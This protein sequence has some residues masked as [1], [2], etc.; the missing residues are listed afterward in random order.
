[1]SDTLD[2]QPAEQGAGEG[3]RLDGDGSFT[4][5]PMPT[6]DLLLEPEAVQDLGLA[7]L[8]P[9]QSIGLVF[10]TP[11]DGRSFSLA[12]RLRNAG[13]DGRL[14]ALG[15]LMPDQAR[16][17]MQSG[18]DGLWLEQD[19]VERHNEAAWRAALDVV[20]ARL[21]SQQRLPASLAG[22]LAGPDIWQQRSQG[23]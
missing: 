11:H 16:H 4:A 17:A 23:Q 2:L 3:W 22:R 9:L 1:M 7:N 8:L 12:R 14:V 19:L 21:Y 5:A 6:L 13:F 20:V 18:F 10:K 15:R